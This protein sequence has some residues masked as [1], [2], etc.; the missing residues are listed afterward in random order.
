MKLII[1]FFLFLICLTSVSSLAIT[2]PIIKFDNVL[3]NSTLEGKFIVYGDGSKYEISGDS[4]TFDQ[5]MINLDTGEKETINFYFNVPERTGVNEYYVYL[6]KITNSNVNEILGIK[7][8]VNVIDKEIK[9]AKITDFIIK[10][11]EIGQLLDIQLKL[12]NEG[13]VI[14]NPKITLKIDDYNYTQELSEIKPLANQPFNLSFPIDLKTGA[15]EGIIILSNDELLDSKEFEFEI[16]EYGALRRGID[17]ITIE[18]ELGSNIIKLIAKVKNTG[19]LNA[20]TYLHTEIYS[21]NK[22]IDIIEGESNLVK[23]NEEKDLISYYKFKNKGQY[24]LVNKIVY[25]GEESQNKELTIEIKNKYL[26]MLNPL[27]GFFIVMLII[28]SGLIIL[29]IKPL[30]HL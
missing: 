15:Y 13:N 22:L 12:F 23:I 7:I 10:N 8:I 18:Y 20:K 4:F 25:E 27:N 3:M 11:I 1:Y 17:F 16:L 5:N 21:D 14:I 9:N 2:P 29:K 30:I 28:I 26:S 6:K 19:E 24:K